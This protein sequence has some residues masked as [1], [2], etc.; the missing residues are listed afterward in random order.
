M[1]IDSSVCI[2]IPTFNAAGT[3]AKTI[4]SLLKQ[5]YLN[6]ELHI[7]DNASEDLTLDIVRSYKD[8]RIFIHR[9]AENI[10]PEGNFNRCIELMNGEFSAIYHSDDIYHPNMLFKQVRCL[11]SNAEIGAVFSSA[12]KINQMDEVIGEIQLPSS[13]VPDGRPYPFLSLFKLVLKSYNFFICPSAMLRT[14]IYKKEIVKWNYGAFKSS[15][16]LDVWLRVSRNHLIGFISNEMSYRISPSQGSEAVRRRVSEADFFL[17]ME[18]YLND[19]EIRVGLGDIDYKN[20]ENL[21]RRDKVSRVLNLFI[22]DRS[23]EAKVLLADFDF[24]AA[25]RSSLSSRS[26]LFT[27]LVGS[28]LNLAINL[29]LPIKWPM[30]LSRRFTS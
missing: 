25:L 23:K 8:P 19:S 7:V 24:L 10:G 20:Y 6:Y 12:K 11:Q 18:S 14:E 13:L 16:D 28:Y 22:E 2:C 21:K 30:K 29:R 4:D 17:V 3:I 1:T 26:S 27:F 9:S 15:S 5:T